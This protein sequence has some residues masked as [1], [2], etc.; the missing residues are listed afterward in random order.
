M[1]ALSMALI[2]N[3][4]KDFRKFYIGVKLSAIPSQGMETTGMSIYR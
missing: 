3:A 1:N 2:V 4:Q